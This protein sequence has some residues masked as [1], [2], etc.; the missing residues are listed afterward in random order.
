MNNYEK[1]LNKINNDSSKNC[2]VPCYIVGPT[3][4]TGP[5]GPAG[6]LNPGAFLVNV[7]GTE[8][9][10]TLNQGDELIFTSSDN[11]VEIEVTNG[12]VIVDLSAINGMS[13]PTGPTGPTGPSGGGGVGPTGPTGATGLTG[14]T[15]PTGPSGTPGLLGPTGPT[16]PI[17]SQGLSGPTGPTGPTGPAGSLNPG[18]ELFNVVGEF[19]GSAAVR[20]GGDLIFRGNGIEIFVSDP[21]T[22]VTFENHMPLYDSA[23]GG[24]F[25]NTSQ[26]FSF[27]G[28]GEET[29]IAFANQMQLNNV[30]KEGDSLRPFIYGDYE[31]N[32]MVRIAPATVSG[33]IAV[34]VRNNGVFVPQSFQSGVLSTEV[35][36]IFQGSFI[37]EIFN[38]NMDLAFSSIDVVDFNL[39]DETNA[40]LTIERLNT[41]F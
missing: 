4:P 6:G 14:S 30:T 34:G 33:Q 29:N 39:S 10:A 22:T 31:V 18:D 26:S 20:F 7:V 16:G 25:S 1:A 8:G 23:Y 12:S 2:K 19:T 40:T 35:D 37:S 32:Y 17:G 15:G 28:S 24:I 13:G 38:A 36:T 11:S 9:N 41:F 5:T 3:G 27:T 21:P